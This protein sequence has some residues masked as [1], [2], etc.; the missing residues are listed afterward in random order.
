MTLDHAPGAINEG[1]LL[2]KCLNEGDAASWE[3]F[4]GQYSGLIWSSIKKTCRTYNYQH[5]DEDAEDLFHSVFL[6]LIEDDFKK[7]RQ[8]R[9]DN[10]C[11]L[12]TWL[13]I[14]ASRRTIDHMRS[15]RS[16]FYDDPVCEGVDIFEMMP[17]DCKSPEHHLEEKQKTAML[18]DAVMELPDQD[19]LIY[20]LLIEKGMSAEETA[21]FMGMEVGAVYSRKNRIIGRLKKSFEGM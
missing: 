1:D 5:S 20:R 6:S 17:S 13:T 12:G 4:V 15:D 2:R 9:A 18:R 10:S 3:L 19:R 16:R 11:S 14:I 8:Y 7:L 21:R